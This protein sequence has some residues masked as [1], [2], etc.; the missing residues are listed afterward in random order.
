MVVPCMHIL[1]PLLC[2]K[3]YSTGLLLR[4]GSYALGKLMNT[5]HVYTVHNPPLTKVLGYSALNVVI[6]LK[7]ATE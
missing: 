6:C 4:A 7:Y 1:I 5:Y 3:C 2:S